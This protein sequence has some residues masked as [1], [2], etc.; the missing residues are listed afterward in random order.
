MNIYVIIKTIW[1][2]NE[3]KKTFFKMCWAD[4][5]LLQKI[6][7]SILISKCM[8]NCTYGQSS[9]QFETVSSFLLLFMF[10]EDNIASKHSTELVFHSQ[11]KGSEHSKIFSL[12]LVFYFMC[13]FDWARCFIITSVR[14]VFSTSHFWVSKNHLIS[15]GLHELCSWLYDKMPTRGWSMQTLVRITSKQLDCRQGAI[16]V[17]R[18]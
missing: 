14:R 17:H 5:Q 12:K 9:S 2:F 6:L 8:C 4:Q 3:S 15:L 13:L 7:A 10:L 1:K 11:I 16:E 18:G